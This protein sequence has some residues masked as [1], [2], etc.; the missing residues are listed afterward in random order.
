LDSS[1]PLIKLAKREIGVM[2]VTCAAYLAGTLVAGFPSG[3]S[4]IED[5]DSIS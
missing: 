4:F 3:R 1:T 2:V 5:S